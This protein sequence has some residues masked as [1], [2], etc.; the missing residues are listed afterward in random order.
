MKKTVQ[1]I[2]VPL[3][4]KGWSKGDIINDGK[5]TSIGIYS[6]EGFG[7][8]QAQQL[9]VLSADEIQE[10]DNVLVNKNTIQTAEKYGSVIGYTTADNV[11]FKY[12]NPREDRPKKDFKIIASYPQ[13]EGTLSISKET[14]QE[15]INA[16]TPGEGTVDTANICLQT[17]ISCGYPCN[18]DCDE[19][20]Y[21]EYVYDPQGNLLLEF[22]EVRTEKEILK[23]LRYAET[24]ERKD[25]FLQELHDIREKESKPSIPTDEEIQEKAKNYVYNK[26]SAYSERHLAG[27]YRE[28]ANEFFAGYK[29]AIKDLGHE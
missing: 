18:G 22:S 23:D 24:P 8:W 7:N 3:F 19:K 1:I 26:C 15:W 27:L 5:F 17:G 29:Q 12:F 2:T 9:L 28:I 10:G 16:G 21:K 20:A 14:I 11:A 4:K 13:L 25:S 6:S